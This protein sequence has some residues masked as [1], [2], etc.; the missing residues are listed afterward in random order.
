MWHDQ[1]ATGSVSVPNVD[2]K[3]IVNR[4]WVITR[5]EAMLER[6]IDGLYEESAA[7]TI[8]LMSRA[9]LSRKRKKG[10]NQEGR[11]PKPKQRNINFPGATA[12][13][14]WNFS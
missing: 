9:N 13:E 14:A 8:T 2:S 10:D 11:L 7:L 5:I 6:I 12:Q 3:L 4:F 1:L